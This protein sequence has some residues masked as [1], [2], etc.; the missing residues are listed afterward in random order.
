MKKL[1]ACALT[2]GLV[3]GCAAKKRNES[4][5]QEELPMM[6]SEELIFSLDAL[7]VAPYCIEYEPC[8]W[9]DGKMYTLEVVTGFPHGAECAAYLFRLPDPEKRKRLLLY[10]VEECPCKRHALL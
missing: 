5:P 2:I 6:E 7:D 4:I 10:E 1:L 8:I 3:L 9:I